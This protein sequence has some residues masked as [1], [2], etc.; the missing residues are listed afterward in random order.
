MKVLELFLVLWDHI[1]RSIALLLAMWGRS[2]VLGAGLA[3][4][5]M[6]R[7]EEVERWIP[8]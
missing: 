6:D 1:T 7:V 2:V 5:C 8:V 3:R 4:H